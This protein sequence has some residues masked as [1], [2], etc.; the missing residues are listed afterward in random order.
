[1]EHPKNRCRHL[2]TAPSL[3]GLVKS[4]YYPYREIAGKYCLYQKIF[5]SPDAISIYIAFKA[6]YRYRYGYSA[7][8]MYCNTYAGVGGTL[9]FYYKYQIPISLWRCWGCHLSFWWDKV[10]NFTLLISYYRIN[11]YIYVL[12]TLLLC[13]IM[14]KSY[15]KIS[16]FPTVPYFSHSQ[17]MIFYFDFLNTVR[18]QIE[19]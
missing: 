9:N 17:W 2:W 18:C 3:L 14:L 16:L 11:A 1:M 8:S 4:A 10:S 6:R 5:K 7:F 13:K 19:P 12:H 15:P